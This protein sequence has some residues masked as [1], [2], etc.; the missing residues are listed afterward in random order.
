MLST[1]RQIHHDVLSQRA[2]MYETKI[3]CPLFLNIHFKLHVE[4]EYMVA[5]DVTGW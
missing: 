4:Y 1:L 3:T 2:A 5:Y